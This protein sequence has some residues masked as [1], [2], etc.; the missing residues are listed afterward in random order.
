MAKHRQKGN[1]PIDY[2]LLVAGLTVVAGAFA[3]AR[4]MYRRAN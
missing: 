1:A 2:G 3:V 4:W